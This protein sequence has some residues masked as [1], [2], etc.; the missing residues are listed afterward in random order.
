MQT[1]RAANRKARQL[2]GD[3]GEPYGIYARELPVQADD[4]IAAPLGERRL[5]EED[6]FSL[7]GIRW[8]DAHRELPC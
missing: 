3:E 8:P 4:F 5:W 2:A 7:L 1:Y 6:G